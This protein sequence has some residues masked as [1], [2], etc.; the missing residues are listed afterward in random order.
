M[1]QKEPR[2]G[3]DNPKEAGSTPS[4]DSN[5]KIEESEK[6]DEVVHRRKIKVPTAHALCEY[7][8]VY[9]TRAKAREDFELWYTISPNFQPMFVSTI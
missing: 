1:Q 4:K 5:T 7:C 2:K 6:T 3:L 8:D 9:N